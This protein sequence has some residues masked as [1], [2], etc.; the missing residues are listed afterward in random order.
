MKSTLKKL[1]SALLVVAMAAGMLAMA[2]AS[3]SEAAS[4]SYDK[5]MTI[6]LW[7]K[8]GTST[9]Y[10]Y[11]GIE[12]HRPSKSIKASSVTS[13]KPSVVEVSGVD[14][15]K[16]YKVSYIDLYAK[17]T[18]TSKITFKV[19]S[20]KY[21]TKVTVK[22]YTNPAK[23]VK[24]TGVNKGKNIAGKTKKKMVYEGLAL[25][26][27]T[28]KVKLKVKA[29]SGWKLIRVEVAD[30]TKYPKDLLYKTYAKGTSKQKTYSVGTLKKSHSYEVQ[31]TF[32]NKKTGGELDSCYYIN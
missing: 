21:T 8:N 14:N 5:K 25:T 2:P 22:S 3:E 20:K 13:S 26:K 18:G 11:G 19:G 12:I 31:L 23:T 32:K 28:K 7:G 9:H 4:M 6:Y 15:D 29:K 1:V 16:K 24:I 10:A 30:Y 17:K 27:T